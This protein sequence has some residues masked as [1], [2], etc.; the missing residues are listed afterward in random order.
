[1][2]AFGGHDSLGYQEY[3][4]VLAMRTPTSKAIIFLGRNAEPIVPTMPLFTTNDTAKRPK[5]SNP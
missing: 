3:I 4:L 1:M 5:N 2:P